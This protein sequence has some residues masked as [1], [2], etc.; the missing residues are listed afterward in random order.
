MCSLKLVIAQA[1]IPSTQ[2]RSAGVA[3]PG[4]TLAEFANR[5]SEGDKRREIGGD[6]RHPFIQIG[7]DRGKVGRNLFSRYRSASPPDLL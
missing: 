6:K 1:C 4:R 3:G 7:S 2:V 5:F